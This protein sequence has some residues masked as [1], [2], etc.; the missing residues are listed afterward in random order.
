MLSARRSLGALLVPVVLLVAAC[1]DDGDERAGEPTVVVTTTVLGDVVERLVGDV[2]DVEVVMPAGADPHSFQP[3][4]RDAAEIRG[5]DAL[6]INGAGFEEGLL[7]VIDAAK[8]DGVPTI[9]A[10]DSVDTLDYGAFE[11][12][13]HED[14][15][16]ADRDDEHG[17]VDPHFFTDPDRMATAAAAIVDFLAETLDGVTGDELRGAAEDHQAEL[18]GLADEVDDLL[19]ELDDDDRTLVTDHDS[20]AYFAD[21]FGFEVVGTVIPSGSTAD[22]ASAAD[23][24]AL[25]DLIRTEGVPAVFV[26]GAAPAELSRALADEAGDVE[27]VELYNGSIGGGDSDAASYAEMIRVDARRIAEALGAG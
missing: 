4:A 26:D 25:A 17:R 12:D 1:G 10:I 18:D 19:A 21:R 7:D 15:D 16:E 2:V 20:M 23:L 6:V 11:D 13:E 22:G 8:G 5:A 24:A 14:E 27:V 9:A 3:S